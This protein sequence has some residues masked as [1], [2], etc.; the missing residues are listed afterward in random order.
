MSPLRSFVCLFVLLSAVVVSG[1]SDAQERSFRHPPAL[2]GDIAP[3]AFDLLAFQSAHSDSTRLDLY[4]AVPFSRLQFLFAVDKYVAEYAVG[5]QVIGNEKLLID[6][7]ETYTVLENSVQHKARLDAREERADAE[8]LSFLLAPGRQYEVRIAIR[9]LTSHRAFDTTFDIQVR[10]FS[11]SGPEMSDLMIYRDKHGM[12][13][14]PS[15]GPD[16]SMLTGNNSGIEDRGQSGVFAELYHIPLDTTLAVVSE[17]LPASSSGSA[18]NILARSVL[19]FRTPLRDSIT[20]NSAVISQMPLFESLSFEDLWTGRYVLRTYLLRS[21]RDTDTEDPAALEKRAMVWN[22]RAI[23]VLAA[24]GVPT[25]AADLDEAIE[26]IRIIATSSELE[27]LESAH[28]AKERRKAI[29]DFWKN[30]NPFPNERSN[31]PMSIFY[32]RIEY[33]NEHFSTGFLPGWKT[34]RGHVYIAL[35]PPSEIETHPEETMQKPY[36]IWHYPELGQR[37][38]FVDEFMMGEYRLVGALPPRGTFLWD[39]VPTH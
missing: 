30:K 10:G 5:L 27:A 35:G 20:G 28:D 29:L 3:A 13:M 31:R 16:V 15:I 39:E 22:E 38:T 18:E 24:R 25:H 2:S 12:R 26:E 37:Y 8:Q 11:E 19:V 14:V 7:Y 6:R 33:A 4:V 21:V 32:G 23:E 9:D 36:E 1:R 17:I 34:D